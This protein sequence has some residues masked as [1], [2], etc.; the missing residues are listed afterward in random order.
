MTFDEIKAL[1]DK[2]FLDALIGIA[3]SYDG[4]RHHHSKYSVTKSERV[5]CEYRVWESFMGSEWRWVGDTA[6]RVS[7][8]GISIRVFAAWTHHTEPVDRNLI[9]LLPFEKGAEQ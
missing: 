8:A 2:E 5:P 3:F 1:P 7:D 6:L 9:E 4:S